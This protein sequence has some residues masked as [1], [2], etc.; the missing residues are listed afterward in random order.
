MKF[1]KYLIIVFTIISISFFPVYAQSYEDNAKGLISEYSDSL[2]D[3]L[4]SDTKEILSEFGF[5]S[6]TY[7]SVFDL[8]FSDII[9]II[10]NSFSFRLKESVSSFSRLFALLIM[11][12]IVNSIREKNEYGI[13]DDVFSLIIIIMISAFLTD[14]ITLL[15]SVFKVTEKFMAALTPIITVILSFSGN[16]TF[17]AVYS[18]MMIGFCQI[19]A[20]LSD[21]VIIPLTGIYFALIIS[22]NFNEITDAER[23][24]S[25]INNTAAAVL[26]TVS[27]VFALL[28]SAKNIL[29]KDIDG[30]LYKSGKYL[31]SS[32]IPVVGNAV[33][34]IL[35]SIVG[36]L[37]IVKS[38]IGIFAVIAVICI[39]LPLFINIFFCRFSLGA[40]SLVS[41]SFGEKKT[42]GLIRCISKSMRLLSIL[43]F[44]ELVTVVIS[45]GLAVSIRGNVQ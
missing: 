45:T 18:A 13:I 27:T 9:D 17:S 21:N 41:D 36:S 26:G 29:A 33:S 19:L 6:I 16:I 37:S 39:N 43:A 7:D 11:I 25:T 34:G 12:I 2:F 23:I 4:D 44:F 42:A 22:M 8:S 20:F 5:E 31:L 35:S 10:K 24:S 15:V 38:T 30:V 3:S 40:I 28:L 1:I 32:I 14:T